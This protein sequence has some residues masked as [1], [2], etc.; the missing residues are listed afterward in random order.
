M[1]M[2]V[3]EL[4][5]SAMAALAKAW[6]TADPD[7]G[8]DRGKGFLKWKIG[9]AALATTFAELL[10]QAWLVPLQVRESL[11]YNFST[12]KSSLSYESYTEQN[13]S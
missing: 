6:E 13:T 1:V 8:E 9:C 4:G 2:Q 11:N 7:Q 3:V 5:F 10:Q 12:L